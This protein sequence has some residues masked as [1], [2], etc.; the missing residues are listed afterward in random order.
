MWDEDD[1]DQ[2]PIE[3][4]NIVDII[5]HDGVKRGSEIVKVHC[6]ICG[7]TFIGPKDKAGIFIKGH[8]E[9][10]VWEVTLYDTL[11]GP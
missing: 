8:K 2:E 1:L 3:E 6:F 4:G 9:F 11:G 5:S 10:H 7:E